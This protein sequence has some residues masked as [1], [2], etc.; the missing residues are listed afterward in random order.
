MSTNR[1]TRRITV[2]LLLLVLGVCAFVVLRPDLWQYY[3]D[4][5]KIRQPGRDAV[6]REVLWEEP[7]LMGTQVNAEPDNYEPTLSA[8]GRTLIFSRGRATQ[9]ADLYMSRRVGDT[10]EEPTPIL[11]LNTPLDELGPELSR[12]GSLLYFY[13]NRDGGFGGYDIWMSR[14][15]AD[16]WGTPVN[17][18]NQINSAYNDYDPAVSPTGRRLYLSSNRP[19][20][21]I[22][23]KERAAWGATLRESRNLSDYDI[24]V[25]DATLVE[26][27]AGNETQSRWEY[28]KATRVEVLNSMADEGQV[29][30]TP[31]G[32][33][34][35]FSSD[36]R[37]G[38]GGFDIY[39]SRIFDGELMLPEH[40]GAP[41]NSSLDDMDPTLWMEGYGLV[42]SS[43]R[44]RREDGE[45]PFRIY[46]SL[47]REV[48]SRTDLSTFDWL[49][50]FLR[51]NKW[52]II[53]LLL[54]LLALIALMRLMLNKSFRRS[55]TLIQRCIV[56]SLLL[57]LLIAFLLSL[58]LV[59]EAVYQA[60][61]EP[62]MEIAINEGALS[63]ELLAL[64]IREQVTELP[65]ATTEFEAQEPVERLPLPDFTP[66]VDRVELE[67]AEMPPPEFV[68]EVESNEAPEPLSESLEAPAISPQLPQL[69]LNVSPFQ[70]ESPSP[71]PP[72]PVEPEMAE[73][74]DTATLVPAPV[75][76]LP[77]VSREI[78][79]PADRALENLP[80]E[81]DTGLASDITVA[82]APDPV[83]DPIQAP[84]STPTMESFNPTE[85]V[86]TLAMEGRVVEIPDTSS[87]AAA[88]LQT[89]SAQNLARAP[90]P[91]PAPN[92]P[93]TTRQEVTPLNETPSLTYLT[94]PEVQ[95]VDTTDPD[96]F[97]AALPK[98]SASPQIER[99]DPVTLGELA[100]ME[101]RE[102]VVPEADGTLPDSQELDSSLQEVKVSP[103]ET[104]VDRPLVG[105]PVASPASQN[106]DP[107]RA[108]EPMPPV[109]PRLPAGELTRP[110]LVDRPEAMMEPLETVLLQDLVQMEGHEAAAPTPTSEVSSRRDADA[111][112]SVVKA[113]TAP[114]ELQRP[115]T[116]EQ[117]IAQAPSAPS[118]SVRIEAA[119]QATN[120]LAAA[121][122]PSLSQP[123]A[124]VPL[125]R[126]I[127]PSS[128][129]SQ[130]RMEDREVVLPA[131]N[132][133]E[134]EAR[135]ADAL[136][137]Q[138]KAPTEQRRTG[139]PQR[140]EPS[141]A[142]LTSTLVPPARNQELLPAVTKTA[143]ALD[144]QPFQ[145]VRLKLT[146]EG[147]ETMASNS[148]VPM[149]A[150]EPV[151][152]E[153]T[154]PENLEI[155]SDKPLNI[156]KASAP[157][158]SR[159]PALMPLRPR[160]VVAREPVQ[161]V[162]G[163]ISQDITAEP[164]RV[165]PVRLDRRPLLEIPVMKRTPELVM[166]D[167]E[168]S[169]QPYLLRDPKTRERLI[170]TLGG[171]DE[172]EAAIVKA[173]DW[174]TRTQARDGSWEVGRFG[175]RR[176]HR[177]AGTGL[178]LLCYLGW[179]A[180]HN[181]PGPY[182]EPVRLAIQFLLDSMSEEGR[183][184]QRGDRGMYDQG[185]ASIALAEAYGVSQDPILK[186][187][188]ER[189]LYFILRSS[190]RGREWRYNPGDPGDTS[191]YGWQVMALKSGLMA[192]AELPEGVLEKAGTWL[193][194]V[195]GGEHGGIYGYTSK[196][197][198]GPG[199]VAE[200]MFC[201]QLL[202]IP[203]TDPR[204]IE[205][206]AHLAERLPR[207]QS[208]DFY[209]FY[210]GCLAL[211]QHQ[212]PI[213]E[214]WN[215]R[216]RALLLSLQTQD[217]EHEGSW[218]A[219]GA[220]PQ[221]YGRLVSTTMAT[222]SLEVYYRYLPLYGLDRN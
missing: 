80:F 89:D 95:N 98:P 164:M 126:M 4:G 174:L 30:L 217:G 115:Q 199:M 3:T 137:S 189:A 160:T 204:M 171:S 172:T 166:E 155:A 50:D 10:W 60:V 206:A 181:E 44:E 15:E 76:P 91:S 136:V 70:L 92:Q 162:P 113:S 48:M 8:D 141:L 133:E 213:W 143:L 125:E 132:N 103:S 198:H 90:S 61:T 182:Q 210:Y 14:R 81:F 93:S 148:L 41:V 208:V 157:P 138:V 197:Y 12:D 87:D 119:L 212:G 84:A 176:G 42:F 32:D 110:S 71:V 72:P 219:R 163:R 29:A 152:A 221:D 179:G 124:L 122:I 118:P 153:I 154:T 23:E 170:Q 187:P 140:L 56:G 102:A 38:Q 149:E 99:Q 193:D 185:I 184:W 144:S 215:E 147:T 5:F 59:S 94:E 159:N 34:L 195:G 39:R 53:A 37:G 191:V 109:S 205:S 28:S 1:A 130:I 78:E 135:L 100:A 6:I 190:R 24:F 68:T 150:R 161:I 222:L 13:S 214:A 194:L 2:G 175:G 151:A 65:S 19:K 211:Y 85:L 22:S 21:P 58:W 145:P 129:S 131:A 104:S 74:T 142:P 33:F 63:R 25:A 66:A 158:P 40:V 45:Y 167:S 18:G 20:G 178:A 220:R 26:E 82:D 73:V 120:R 105:N 88:P 79:A 168:A 117:S 51:L 111:N 11:Q 216:M 43:N 165:E 52:W 196:R 49:L 180:K 83:V 209:Y 101:N 75:E 123:V 121:R 201:Q 188:V 192:G 62:S 35:Y 108:I 107:T 96:A 200:G 202:G 16:R 54:A 127:H 106:P 46:H 146:M 183:L 86:P 134:A 7:E 173:L 77:D 47:S 69:T 67:S 128:K 9:N 17:L 177:T 36:R 207:R 156:E 97:S 27:E 186:E 203:R 55:L 139:L 218:R 114:T 116:I 112:L 31:R 64:D 57:H 169:S